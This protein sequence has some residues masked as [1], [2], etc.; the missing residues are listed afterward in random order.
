MARS[1]DEIIQDFKDAKT[2]LEGISQDAADAIYDPIIA[3]GKL[4][5][6]EADIVKERAVLASAER[7]RA[8]IDDLR[9][10]ARSRTRRPRSGAPS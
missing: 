10:R 9:R 1:L 4:A 8:E 3:K 5:I 2:E 7:K 6:V